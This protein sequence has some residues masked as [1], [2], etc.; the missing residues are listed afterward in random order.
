M[1]PHAGFDVSLPLEA[2]AGWVAEMRA[3]LSLMN[4][5]E[6]QTYG[7]LGDGNL[8]LVV[9]QVADAA[10]KRRVETWCTPA[11]ARSAARSPVNTA[12]G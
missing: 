2:M 8:H 10:A 7:H 4:L 12:S 1:A 3:R 11:S 9:G 6:V 5:G